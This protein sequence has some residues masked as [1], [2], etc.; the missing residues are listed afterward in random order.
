MLGR[1]PQLAHSR[2]L[3][4]SWAPQWCLRTSPPQFLILKEKF[5]LYFQN[6][7]SALEA[8]SGISQEMGLF[9]VRKWGKNLNYCLVSPAQEGHGPAGV[10][11]KEAT[12]FPHSSLQFHLSLQKSAN[13]QGLDDPRLLITECWQQQDH[14]MHHVGLALEV[15]S[16]SSPFVEAAAKIWG[17]VIKLPAKPD[18]ILQKG[19]ISAAF[20]SGNHT[21]RRSLGI[22]PDQTLYKKIF[23]P[24]PD[25]E[26]PTCQQCDFWK[27]TLS[28]ILLGI[29]H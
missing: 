16:P 1:P 10:S 22:L 14:G 11:P 25:G 26:E 21:R 3:L 17:L 5:T 23:L 13:Y 29:L 12:F 7:E 27:S 4:P 18:Q 24:V 8:I 2:Y 6:R 20:F 19:R 9:N 28:S 15:S